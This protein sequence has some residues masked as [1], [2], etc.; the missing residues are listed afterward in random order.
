MTVVSIIVVIVR[1]SLYSCGC[2]VMV[3]RL[4][5]IMRKPSIKDV[6]IFVVDVGLGEFLLAFACYASWCI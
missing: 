1:L 2:T 4:V 5:I 3:G 6:E